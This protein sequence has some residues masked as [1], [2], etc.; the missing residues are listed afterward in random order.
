MIAG[1]F[2]L[3][4]CFPSF[5]LSRVNANEIKHD[6]SLVVIVVLDLIYDNSHKALYT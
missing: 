6:H 3:F 4:A 5:H 2:E 1:H